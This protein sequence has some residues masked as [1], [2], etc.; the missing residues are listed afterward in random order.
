M[1]VGDFDTKMANAEYKTQLQQKI[2]SP[3][4]NHQT[5]IAHILVYTNISRPT[6]KETGPKSMI[7]GS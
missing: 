2:D 6:K 1:I 4:T 3:A 5:L 7:L